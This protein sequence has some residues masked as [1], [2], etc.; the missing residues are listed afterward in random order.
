MNVASVQPPEQAAD[1]MVKV[2]ALVHP[3]PMLVTIGGRVTVPPGS[4]DPGTTTATAVGSVEHPPPVTL[5]PFIKYAAGIC[6]EPGV[7]M[8]R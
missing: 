8:V 1:G 5:G 4:C 6:P 3:I 2:D 7:A